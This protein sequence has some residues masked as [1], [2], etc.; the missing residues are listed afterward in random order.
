[1]AA[2]IPATP[3]YAMGPGGV[4]TA[5]TREQD[6][7]YHVDNVTTVTRTAPG[8][9][10]ADASTASISATI[11]NTV[12]QDLWMA[13]A[14]EG[15]TRTA[16]DWERF[17][18]ENGATRDITNNFESFDA[19]LEMAAAATGLP[20]DNIS[21]MIWEVPNFIDDIPT[22]HDWQLYAALAILF[23]LLALVAFALLQKAK[24]AAAAAEDAE[25][26]LSVEDL[27]VSTQLEEAKEE[28]AEEFEAIDY[29][30]ENEIKK[31]IEK[32][33]NEKPEAVAALLR[34]WIN[35]EEW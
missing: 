18:L 26:E 32:F 28:A 19:V 15:E 23:L 27:L 12:R 22:M 29:F 25:P 10:V 31:H 14:E 16:Q 33:V 17:K 21:L 13:D 24:S 4:T 6:V 5:S 20:T 9:V 3:A 35:A 30:K 11:I 7:R 34:N 1:M 8:W 2:Q